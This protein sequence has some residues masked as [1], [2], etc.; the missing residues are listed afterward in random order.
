[1]L[2]QKNSGYMIVAGLM[3]AFF[4][5]S[6]GWITNV[7]V[8]AEEKY[9]QK[10][11]QIVIGYSPGA[12]D[13][14]LRPFTEKMQEYLKQPM[15]FVYKPG[16]AGSVGA[17]FVAKAKPDG[18]TLVGMSQSPVLTTTLTKE[19]DYTLDDFAPICQVVKSPI[20][21]A[22]KAESRLKSIKDVIDESK[23]SPG[24]ITYSTSGVLGSTHLPTE[25]FSKAAGIKLTHVPCAGTGPAVTALLGGHVDMT[26]S[27]MAAIT[28]HLKSGALRS[29]AFFEKKRLKAFPDAPTFSELGYP[30][31][32]SVDYGFMAPKNTEAKVIK[33][34]DE[35]AKKAMKDQINYIEDRTG[36]MSLIVDYLNTEEFRDKLKAEYK[37]L[38]DV[39]KEMN[40]LVKS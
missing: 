30:F 16:S 3:T 11:I 9:P 32:F 10:A 24:K 7:S 34:I 17:S 5:M 29:L 6:M 39:L 26:T 35:A 20:V 4:L 37:T 28:P 38:K 33:T 18:Y 31:V 25:V 21:I 1:M 13:A 15:V 23:K 22:V 27:T 8:A 14:A 19:V 2:N 40:A 12:T 36:K